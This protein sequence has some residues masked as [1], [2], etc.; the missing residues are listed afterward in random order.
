MNRPRLVFTGYTLLVLL[1]GLFPA[2]L[3]AGAATTRAGGCP[4]GT[5]CDRALGIALTPPRDWRLLPPGKLPA[6][7]IAFYK[8]PVIGPSYNVRLVVGSDGTTAERNDVRAAAQAANRLTRGYTHLR[9]PIVRISVRYGGAPGVMV[10]NLPGPPP[11]VAVFVLAHQGA[12]YGIVAPGRSLAPDQRRALTNLRFIS[13]V[14]PFPPANP[15]A[16]RSHPLTAVRPVIGA[17][18]ASINSLLDLSFADRLHG[19]ALGAASCGSKACNRLALGGTSNGGRTWFPLP[20]P[21]A[22]SAWAGATAANAAVGSIRF[23]DSNIGWIFGPAVLGTWTGGRTWIRERVPG[24]VLA[25]ASD[26]S[27]WAIDRPCARPFHCRLVLLIT[28]PAIRTWWR[29]SSLPRGADGRDL[30]LVRT[31]T[32]QAWLSSAQQMTGGVMTSS[33]FTTR[34]AG[35]TWQRLPDPCRLVG[36]VQRLAARDS[37]R[38]WLLCAGEPSGGAQLKWLYV[39]QDGGLHWALTSSTQSGV[40]RLPSGGY[41][42]SFAASDASHLWLALNRGTLF[43]SADGGRSW[44]AAVPIERANPGGGGVGPVVFVDPRHGWFANWPHAV[45]RT[46]D[47]GRHWSRVVVP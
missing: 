30:Q 39:S 2:R 18:K 26:G 9:H 22:Q 7:T 36:F 10:L 11:G 20:A 13:R 12:L 42:H 28:W 3:L 6:H 14:G 43:E 44:S 35:R 47:G 5:V 8:P 40:R 29:L 37:H 32:G 31:L 15:P 1:V 19:W 41:V 46:D 34:D 27:T 25:L 33:L 45:F 4:S 24:S 21:P 38:L 17:R 23:A 16:P